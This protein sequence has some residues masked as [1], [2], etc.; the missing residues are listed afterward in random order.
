[1]LVNRWGWIFLRIVGPRPF[2]ISPCFQKFSYHFCWWV[3]LIK[4]LKVEL[5]EWWTLREE[6]NMLPLHQCQ[7]NQVNTSF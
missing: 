6:R 5:K 4:D 7:G 3:K 1:M 2:A